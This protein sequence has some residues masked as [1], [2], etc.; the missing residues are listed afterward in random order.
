MD[1]PNITMKEY[2]KLE[3]EKARKRGKVFN[4]ET[5]KYGKIWNDEDIH[6]LKSVEIEFPAIAF[7]D[8]VSSKALS[9]EPT[10]SSLN[11]EINFRISFDDSDDEDYTGLEYSDA[12]IADFKERLQRIYSREIQ[13]VQVVYF[14]GM[15]ELVRDG[16]FSRIV[17]EHRDDAGI[18]IFTSRACGRLFDTREPL[19]RSSFWSSLARLDFVRRRWSPQVLL[20]LD[21]RSGNIPYLLARYLRRFDAGKKSGAHISGG[22]FVARLTKHFGLLT[23]EIL[24]GLMVITPELL[25]IDMGE[26]VRLQICIEVDYTW[27]WVA[28]GLERQH[29]AAAVAPAIAEDVPAIDEDDQAVLAPMQAPQ[30]PPPPPPAAARTM[31]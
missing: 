20:G 10:V 12:N 24:R 19:V 13:R 25:I 14:Q 6:D 17:M 8:E 31:P 4:W 26:L 5:A 2:I 27:A 15:P 28:M 9:C 22:Q 29:D 18:V 30:Q 21:V 1:D 3:E 23:A 16:L 11:N 7:N